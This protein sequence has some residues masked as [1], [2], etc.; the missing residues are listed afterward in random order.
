MNGLIIGNSPGL[1]QN[2]SGSVA[3]LIIINKTLS[4][5]DRQTIERNQG[6]FYGISASSANGTAEVSGYICSTASAGTMSAGALVSGVTQTITATVTKEGTYNISATANGVT[7]AGSGVFT[8]TGSQNIILR[9][10]G[11]PITQGNQLFTLN[12]STTCSFS[13]ATSQ[14]STN[15]TA[16]VSGYNCTTAS[17]GTMLPGV[18]VSAG[19]T[20]TITANVTATGTYN[21]SA[22]ANGVTFA[23]SGTFTITGTQDILLRATGTPT[24]GGTHSFAL[25]TAPT[26]S[27][28]RF[29]D[30]IPST[31]SA[32]Y[33]LRKLNT[34]YSGPAIRVRR[35]HYNDSLDI[36]FTASGD[37]DTASLKAFMGDDNNG[38]ITTWYDQSGNGRNATQTTPANQPQIVASGLIHRKNSRPAIRHIAANASRLILSTNYLTTNN[39]T[40]NVVQGLD[41]GANQRMLSGDPGWILGFWGD[42]ERVFGFNSNGALYNGAQTPT[43][44]N[45]LYTAIGQG[46]ATA[47]VF[48]NGT[49]ISAQGG[50]DPSNRPTILYTSSNGVGGE[51]SNGSTQ[52]IIVFNS[53]LSTTARKALERNQAL[54]YAINASSANGTAEVSGYTC[55]IDSAG[56][57]TAGVPVS[58][59][60]QTIRATVTTPGTYNISATTNGVTFAASGTFA[61]TGSQNIVLTATGTPTA[62]G[63]QS[64]M[65]NTSPTCSFSRAINQPSTNGTAIVSGFDCNTASAGN[66]AVGVA[67]SGVTQTIRATVTSVG[68]YNISATTNGVTFAAS[69]TFSGTPPFS[70]NIT[71]T[72]TGTPTGA[73]TQLYILNTAPNCSFS[74]FTDVIP[75]S[76]QNAAYSL[77]KFRSAYSGAA[78]NVRSSGGAT[79]DIGFTASGD[80][81]TT[82]LKAFVGVGNNGFVTTWYDQSGNG[83][84]AIQ[85]TLV[86]QPQIVVNGI[87]QTENG[88]PVINFSGAAA[89]SLIASGFT[90]PSSTNRFI[91][92]VQKIQTYKNTG[93]VW[94]DAGTNNFGLQ[95]DATAAYFFNG[96][97]IALTPNFNATNVFLYTLNG[98]T[99]L[100]NGGTNTHSVSTNSLM[101]G[102]II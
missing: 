84:N 77:R 80:L 94:S 79:Q 90:L 8:V 53:S 66:M 29:T 101:N 100:I 89:S 40:V 23:A 11:T 34:D 26:C 47:G 16:I 95:S 73:G 99:G 69:G 97:P 44:A 65:L 83:K 62:L 24:D 39:W 3:E 41:G 20:Q 1:S 9:A 87:V 60:S 59:V 70:Q 86:N 93:V 27:F 42:R 10:S 17:A 76:T 30:I 54:F 56:T 49:D 35:G 14:P 19:V 64:F 85:T 72:A 96:T 88:R 43:T 32:A 74:R 33:S 81:D 71:L 102:L 48:R 4:T 18:L 91:S 38:F 6:E 78:I 25:N 57:M 21:I 52:E 31:T 82:A 12:T 46:S 61:D 15:G 63:N 55:S 7:F 50:G 58:G 51:F 13:R 2:L 37:L 68:T 67:V 36:G 92:T 5:T 98:T 45:Q 28:S 75:P 22:T